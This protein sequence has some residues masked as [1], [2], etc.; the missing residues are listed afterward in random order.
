MESQGYQD[1][2][3]RDDLARCGF[4]EYR[5]AG[6]S[7]LRTPL[8]LSFDGDGFPILSGDTPGNS[9]TIE[10]ACES[11]FQDPAITRPTVWRLGNVMPSM[12]SCEGTANQAPTVVVHFRA[13][14]AP[15]RRRSLL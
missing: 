9:L 13:T 3:A 11:L 7:E 6:L 4:G 14:Q 5:S 1:C 10:W 15:I 12:S 8:L 2:A